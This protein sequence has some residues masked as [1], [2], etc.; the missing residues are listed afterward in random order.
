MKV[1]NDPE[2]KEKVKDLAQ[3]M[4]AAG[5][6]LDMSTIQELQSSFGSLVKP[7]A[8]HEAENPA[9]EEEE[10]QHG[11]KRGVLNKMKGLFKK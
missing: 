11:R 3:D 7:Q 10:Q 4:Q 8:E 9:E 6:Q 1:M 2:V 5:I